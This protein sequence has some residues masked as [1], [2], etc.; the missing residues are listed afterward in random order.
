MD[1]GTACSGSSDCVGE[2]RYE[3]EAEPVPQMQVSGTCQ[4]TDA[5]FGCY[6]VVEDG[7]IAYTIC[8]D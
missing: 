5:R 8:V 4:A 1:A 6:S 2:C 3:G 7:K